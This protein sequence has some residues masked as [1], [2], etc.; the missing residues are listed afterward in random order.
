MGVRRHC[1]L[2]TAMCMVAA[3]RSSMLHDDA[4]FNWADLYSSH[5]GL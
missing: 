2:C 1:N 3:T 4:D 5:F